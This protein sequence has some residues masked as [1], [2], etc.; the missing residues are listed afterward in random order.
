MIA[1]SWTRSEYY[2]IKAILNEKIPTRMD[3]FKMMNVPQ[4]L[5]CI[6]KSR[7]NIF[8]QYLDTLEEMGELDAEELVFKNDVGG[9]FLHVLETTLMQKTYKMVILKAFF[10]NGNIKMAL[11]EKDILDVWKDFF[12]EG[13][14]WKDLGVESYQEFLGITDEQH[15]TN[16]RKNP[17]K[18]LLLSGQGFFVERPGYAIALAEELKD[19]VKSD[20]LIKHF[21]DIIEY[22][23]SEYFRKKSF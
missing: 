9:E 7:E 13:D 5:F 19:V 14:N 15:L 11:T 1:N 18:H 22:R 17:I 16:A 21:G 3:L 8:K 12:A 6:E 4:Y 20:I 2:R 10:N 23:I